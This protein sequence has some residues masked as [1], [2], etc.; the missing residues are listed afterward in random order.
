MLSLTASYKQP[1]KVLGAPIGS[2]S[3]A[4]GGQRHAN[5]GR[6]TPKTLGRPAYSPSAVLRRR[7]GGA[8]RCRALRSFY[9]HRMDIL[10]T[11]FAIAGEASIY[12]H[13]GSPVTDRRAQHAVSLI[14]NFFE[15]LS[16]KHCVEI[17]NGYTIQQWI[18]RWVTDIFLNPRPSGTA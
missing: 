4:D 18:R 1:G 13:S 7:E 9:Q 3:D 12:R 16:K 17:L 15:S 5:L 14:E 2:G 8:R 11:Q 10:S 6:A